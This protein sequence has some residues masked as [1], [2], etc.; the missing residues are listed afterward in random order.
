M[1]LDVNQLEVTKMDIFSLLEVIERLP[2]LSFKYMGAYSVNKNPHL[3]KHS[4]AI[5]YSAPSNDRGEHMITRFDKS[6]YFSDSLGNK[7]STYAFL[8]KKY[9]QMVPRELKKTGDNNTG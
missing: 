6:Y 4:F 7:R 2:E 5:F 8:S 1:F 3:T 9:R